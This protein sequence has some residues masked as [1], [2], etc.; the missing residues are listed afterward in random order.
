MGKLA[1][2]LAVLALGAVAHG[3]V[4]AAAQSSVDAQWAQQFVGSWAATLQT[5]DGDVPV[6]LRVLDEN[7][8]VGV[9]L[10]NDQGGMDIEDVQ[11]SGEAL[12]A[13]Y[14]MDYQGMEIP[15]VIRMTRDGDALATSWSFADGMYDTSARATRQ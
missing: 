2:A 5:P 12:V 1:L 8:Q 6:V 3:P 9:Q 7:G 15:A 11:R 4:T 13:R 14:A 10:G